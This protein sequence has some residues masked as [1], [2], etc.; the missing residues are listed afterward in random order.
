MNELAGQIGLGLLIAATF[1]LLWIVAPQPLVGPVLALTP[2]LA[3]PAL[4]YPFIL[5]LTFVVFSFFR[6][7]EVFPYLMPLKLPKLLALGTFASLGWSIAFRRI[8]LF[9]DPLFTPFVAF[10]IL[11]GC[12]VLLATNFTNSFDYWKETFVKIG[13]MVFAIS[14]S[15]RNERDFRLGALMIVT[16]AGVVATVALLNKILGIGLVEGT[17][18]TIGREIGSVLGDPNDLSLV[19]LFGASFALASA[20]GRGLPLIDRGLGALVFC[21]VTL[22]ILATQSRGGLLGL[23]A[24]TGVFVSERIKSKLTLGALAA[25]AL[26]ALF[27]IS[28]IDGRQSGGAHEAGIDESAMGRIHAWSAAFRMAIDNPLAGVGLDNFYFNYFS[29]SSFWDGQNHAV[30]STWFG[31]LA[32][33]GFLGFVAFIWIVV[34]VLVSIR[35]SKR[36]LLKQEFPCPVLLT[37][38]RGL[39]GGVVGFCI[40][41]TFLTQ[42]F[43]GPLSIILGLGVALGR[44]TRKPASPPSR[45]A[46]P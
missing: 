36:R 15:L 12:G 6:I 26:L 17:R 39:L 7:H 44:I 42:A 41:G 11:V 10:F 30:H 3:I 23:V 40:G 31:V 14:W 38:A 27:V 20:T 46:R 19:L 32:E 25:L 2:L 43:T 35:E 21:T 4:R 24:V 16:A 22:A 5:C 33:T 1:F 18:V 37:S 13:L 9:W 28:G 45:E 34:A 8:K 29:Y